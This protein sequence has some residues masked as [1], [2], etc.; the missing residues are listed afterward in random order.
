MKENKG[1]FQKF[2]SIVERVGNK[3]PNPVLLFVILAFAVI[4]SSYIFSLFGASV[5][6]PDTGEEEG[7]INMISAEGLEHI[8]TSMLSNFTGFAPLGLILSMMIGIGLAEKV[9]LIDYV[10]RKTLL[11][12]PSY[13]ITYAVVFI[14]VLGNLASDAAVVI[15]PPLA[16]L[17]FYKVGRHPLAGVA[18]GFAGAASG[19]TANLFIAGTDALLSGIST[20]AAQI[21]DKTAVVTPVDNWYFNSIS[22]FMITIVAGLVTTKIVE[23][24][25]GKYTG[26]VVDEEEEIPNAKKGFFAAV[27][28]GLVYILIVVVSIAFPNSP[29]RGEDGGIINSPFMDGIVPIILIFFLIIGLA[30]GITVGKLNQV[31]T[32]II[33]WL[34][35]LSP[36]QDLLLWPLR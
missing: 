2:L 33:I 21:I 27:F 23:P 22:V 10:I 31:M 20:E 35:R 24:R 1:L 15:V 36:C 5:V 26:E 19:F 25:L 4:I 30:F 7:I 14:G 12:A 8:L 29:L 28:A 3:L 18:A 9:G 11:K 34:N 16:A 32:P 6:N 13:L 17:V